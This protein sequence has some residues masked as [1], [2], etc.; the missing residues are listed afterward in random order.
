MVKY[1]YLTDWTGVIKESF[2]KFDLR[3]T[4][5]EIKTDSQIGSNDIVSFFVV[6]PVVYTALRLVIY[7]GETMQYELVYCMTEKATLNNVPDENEKVWAIHRT[8]DPDAV[9]IECN[10]VKVADFMISECT[11]SGKEYYG[12][13]TNKLQFTSTDTASDYFRKKGQGKISNLTF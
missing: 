5:L 8:L 4:P 2:I 7:F 6:D 3:A 11:N 1:Q 12:R 9:K 10:G 13:S